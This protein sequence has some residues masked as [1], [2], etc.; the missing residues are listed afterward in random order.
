MREMGLASRVAKACTP[1]LL[2][3]RPLLSERRELSNL[4]GYD[5]LRAV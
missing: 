3:S 1:T 5:R 4:I 2:E